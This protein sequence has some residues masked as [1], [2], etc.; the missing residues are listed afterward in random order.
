[1]SM[2]ILVSANPRKLTLTEMNWYGFCNALVDMA[3]VKVE[4][5]K[6]G[7][8]GFICN[9]IMIWFGFMVFNVTFNN[10]SVIS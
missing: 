8:I 7:V 10:I 3:V 1:M 6:T 9:I 4:T 2:N 5:F